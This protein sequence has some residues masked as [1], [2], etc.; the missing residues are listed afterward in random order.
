MADQDRLCRAFGLEVVT[1]STS[2]VPDIE[3]DEECQKSFEEVVLVLGDRLDKGAGS[4]LI[5]SR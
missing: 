5:T 1:V 4:L 3:D 2:G